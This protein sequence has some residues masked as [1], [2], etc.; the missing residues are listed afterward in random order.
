MKGNRQVCSSAGRIRHGR[1]RG[2][3]FG[4]LV[5]LAGLVALGLPSQAL[6]HYANIDITCSETTYDYVGFANQPDNVTNFE[7]I[8]QDDPAGELLSITGQHGFGSANGTG[9]VEH[10]P[11][12]E[13]TY[14]IAAYGEWDTNGHKKSYHLI[15]MANVECSTPPEQQDCTILG[16]IFDDDP[17]L[18]DGDI[19]PA[20]LIDVI[21]GFAGNDTLNGLMDNDVLRGMSGDDTLNGGPGNDIL[22]G[23]DGDDTFLDDE[24]DDEHRGGAGNDTILDFVGENRVYG[25]DGDDSIFTGT[26]SDYLNGDA[27]NDT[28]DAGD[29]NDTVNGGDGDDVI[30]G[31][32]GEDALFGGAGNDTMS[33]ING[34]N[35][36]RGEDGD[37]LLASGPGA[38]QLFGGEGDDWLDS[39]GG[40]DH[41]DGGPGADVFFAGSGDDTI[42]SRHDDNEVDVIHCGAGNDVVFYREGDIIIN[43]A[44]DPDWPSDDVCETTTLVTD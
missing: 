19:D 16:T 11:L 43:G 1:I 33:D 6:A 39:D 7:V 29:G 5:A 41:L 8:I 38:D 14:S 4:L 9:V 28:F 24:G 30:E 15:G 27:G 10:P 20:N 35:W 25:G 37:D 17:P 32:N 42:Y 12:P 3:A 18:L 34:D 36:L 44:T 31:G 23:A 21:C 13:G 40:D 2:R 26:G 22:V